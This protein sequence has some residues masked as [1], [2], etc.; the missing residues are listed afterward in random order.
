MASPITR[1]IPEHLIRLIENEYEHEVLAP[2]QP[3]ATPG[4]RGLSRWERTRVRAIGAIREFASLLSLT[5]IFIFSRLEVTLLGRKLYF[6]H[7][8]F[9]QPYSGGPAQQTTLLAH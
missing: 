8:T 3:T 2:R 9:E 7:A 4:P 5:A 1:S 6:R